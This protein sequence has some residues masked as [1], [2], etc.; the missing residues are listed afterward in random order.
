MRLKR[1]LREKEKIDAPA[2][3][4]P[5][6]D[7]RA[8]FAAV[9]WTNRYMG[10]AGALIGP[11]ESLINSRRVSSFNILDVGC[12]GGDI[13]VA[14]VEWARKK[15]LGMTILGID[16]HP[17]A[18][19]LAK[20]RTAGYPEINIVLSDVF[21]TKFPDESFDVVVGSLL[22]HHLSADQLSFFLWKAYSL[23]RVGVIL[24]DLRRSR[25]A[26]WAAKR[27]VPRLAPPS[28]IFNHD[29]P[30]SFRRAYTLKEIREFLGKGGFPYMAT[31]PLLSPFRIVLSAERMNP[32]QG[33]EGQ[34]GFK[35]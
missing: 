17:H 30:L 19:K 11:L 23:S 27:I 34:S 22:L 29:A 6:E 13:D 7:Y 26:H 1:E 25:P 5:F 3:Q 2:D 31:S 9:E 18:V 8:A 10:G 28:A 4:V 24:T 14:L 33:P 35:R 15:E 12:G 20:E 16:S 21:E 32:G